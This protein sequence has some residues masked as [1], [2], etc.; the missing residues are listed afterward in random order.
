MLCYRYRTMTVCLYF[1]CAP[2]ITATVDL[3]ERLLQLVS[4]CF[5]KAF[6]GIVRDENRRRDVNAD[7]GERFRHLKAI[8]TF[9]F[10][11]SHWCDCERENR[12]SGFFCQQHRAHFREVTRSPGAIDRKRGETAGAHQSHH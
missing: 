9:H 10:P 12:V 8:P 2:L 6:V 7:A 4:L 3:V 11:E 5:E 1:N